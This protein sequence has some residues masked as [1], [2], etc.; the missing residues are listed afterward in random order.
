MPCAEMMLPDPIHHHARGQRIL[1]AGHPVGDLQAS[2][3]RC[4][5]RLL[6]T[7]DHLEKTAR[8]LFAEILVI[9]ANVQPRIVTVPILGDH[10]E[11]GVG[12]LRF[13][14]R[15]FFAVSRGNLRRLRFAQYPAAASA[16]TKIRSHPRRCARRGRDPR[17][18]SSTCV[19]ARRSTSE[20]SIWLDRHRA[21]CAGPCIHRRRS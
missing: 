19:R 20:F 11:L 16:M 1:G 3:A 15:D 4:D 5:R 13:E 18:R 6:L 9:A 21:R 8:H 10:R 12:N 14:L 7:C 17:S 2:A